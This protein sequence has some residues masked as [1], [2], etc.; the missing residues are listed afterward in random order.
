[1]YES[2]VGENMAGSTNKTPGS[3]TMGGVLARSG[4][5]R[6]MFSGESSPFPASACS[7]IYDSGF[8]SSKNSHARSQ[9]HSLLRVVPVIYPRSGN[10]LNSIYLPSVLISPVQSRLRVGYYDRA[11]TQNEQNRPG[12]PYTRQ[13][14]RAP[15]PLRDT[16]SFVGPGV[17]APR[18]LESIPG[19]ARK[20]RGFLSIRFGFPG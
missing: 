10:E 1:M 17:V 6:S 18:A 5:S 16:A 14:H 7:N 11:I 9:V 8:Q 13:T 19:D 4:W 15:P 2:A 12:C 3:R 20:N